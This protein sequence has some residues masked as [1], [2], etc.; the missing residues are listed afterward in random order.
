MGEKLNESQQLLKDLE[1]RLVDSENSRRTEE[2]ISKELQQEVQ[3][4]QLVFVCHLNMN[5]WFFT[6]VS[7]E[8]FDMYQLLLLEISGSELSVTVLSIWIVAAE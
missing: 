1:E 6:D 3:R 4:S 2:E 7:A 5:R 8:N